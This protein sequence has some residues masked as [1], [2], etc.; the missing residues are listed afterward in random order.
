[1]KSLTLYKGRYKCSDYTR[2]IQIEARL[3]LTRVMYQSLKHR[4]HGSNGCSWTSSSMKESMAQILFRSTIKG[5]RLC[6]AIRSCRSKANRGMDRSN[7]DQTD[8]RE[9]RKESSHEG[10]LW[11]THKRSF[12]LKLIF[13][14]IFTCLYMLNVGLSVR[15]S[16]QHLYV[17][18][19]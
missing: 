19:G 18:E 4:S 2:R 11:L 14:C 3:V 15:W 13:F 8:V 1:M 9:Q 10:G 17:H 5:M 7:F 12:V 16:I 6:E